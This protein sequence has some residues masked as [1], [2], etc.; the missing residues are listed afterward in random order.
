MYLY[1]YLFIHGNGGSRMWYGFIYCLR[2]TDSLRKI[3][4]VILN[5]QVI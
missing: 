5:L 1:T 3:N 4:M 2:V